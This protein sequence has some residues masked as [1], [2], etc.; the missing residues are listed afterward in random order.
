MPQ[1]PPSVAAPWHFGRRVVA[2]HV[3]YSG[4]SC[5]RVAW[6]RSV[7]GR[8]ARLLLAWPTAG[9]AVTTDTG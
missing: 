2:R 5:F 7:C 3:A 9:A 1:R 4:R 8:D 6:I